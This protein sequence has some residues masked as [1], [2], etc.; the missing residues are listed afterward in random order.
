M[1]DKCGIMQSCKWRQVE[2]EN[3]VRPPERGPGALPHVAGLDEAAEEHHGTPCAAP[4]A[5][6][7][8]AALC[9]ALAAG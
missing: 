5:E 6:C 9:H 1:S 4:A 2:R 3:A 7:D 8:P